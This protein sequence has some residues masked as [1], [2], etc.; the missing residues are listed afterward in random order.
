MDR[1]LWP[2]CLSLAYPQQSVRRQF[3]FRI[4]HCATRTIRPGKSRHPGAIQPK[5]GWIMRVFDLDPARAC[6]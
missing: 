1:R 3:R 5:R 4:D 6:R 2:A